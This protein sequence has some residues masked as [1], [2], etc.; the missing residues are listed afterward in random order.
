MPKETGN[1]AQS[2]RFVSVNRVVV[3]TKRLF[4]TFHPN[5]IE[6]TETFANK[7]IKV[8]VGPFLRTTFD[9]HVHEFNL[10]SRFVIQYL[11]ACCTRTNDQTYLFAFLELDLE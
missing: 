1:I 11:I 2:V 3:V 9:N 5:T 8:G 6:F 10:K 4:D 7:P